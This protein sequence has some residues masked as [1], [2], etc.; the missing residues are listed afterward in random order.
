MNLWRSLSGLPKEI[1]ILFTT[2]L[3]NRAGTMALPFLVLY[4][5]QNLNLP[6]GR[7]GLVITAYGVGSL[8]TSP[9]A[10]R[11]CDRIGALRIMKLSLFLTGA[12]LLAFPLA[13]GFSVILAL[14]I[15]WAMVSE[16]FRP[17]SLA[18]T[19]DLVEPGQLRAA[20]S[21]SRLAVNL[22]MSIGPAVGG[23]LATISFSAL[24][25]VDGA[26]AILAGVV[27]AAS[28]WRIQH[29]AAPPAIESNDES[30][31]SN[32]HRNPLTDLRFL[33]FLA[34]M[35]PASLVLFQ[36]HAAMALFLVRDLRL[37]ESVYGLLF[38]INTLLI[39]L[40]EVPLNTAMSHWPHR[41]TLVLGALL[42]GIGFGALAFVTGIFGVVATVVVWTFGEMILVPAAAAYVAEISNMKRRGEYMGL[43]QMMYGLAFAIGPWLGTQVLETFGAR[44]LWIATF[45][46]GCLSA[47]MLGRVH[48]SRV[49]AKT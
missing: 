31:S 35:V 36:I 19:A 7:A 14:T 16:A 37:S 20:Y 4:L 47:A 40:I 28:R 11:L 8:V 26:T 30:D 12:I 2:T 24:F 38:T 21:V 3:V 1:W 5:T 23:F 27:L 34:A 45:V 46:A 13:R 44:T 15:V 9:L 18:I 22:G 32:Q 17:A 42:W 39:V 49:E 33:Y 29:H 48:V 25:L 41:P 43:Y 10:G 6:A